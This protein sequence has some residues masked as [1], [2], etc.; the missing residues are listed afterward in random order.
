VGRTRTQGVRI[1]GWGGWNIKTQTCK[2]KILT[3]CSENSGHEK[4]E[5][6]VSSGITLF[7]A[8]IN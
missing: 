1:G 3:D 6:N 2:L 4:V 7:S 8:A 5:E